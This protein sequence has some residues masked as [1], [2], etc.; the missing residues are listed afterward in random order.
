M[1]AAGSSIF[2]RIAGVSGFVAVVAGA[3][4]A[5]APQFMKQEGKIHQKVM[6]TGNL[7]H[8]IHTLG[9]LAVPFSN[10]PNLTGGL[11]CA[12]MVLFSGS[13]Y[14]AAITQNRRNG[15]LAPIGGVTLMAAWLT[16]LL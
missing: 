12:G 16:L 7:Y 10:R 9:L 1:A 14:L 13:C 15:L 2:Y 11:M 6:E 4:G 5:H 8:L 3:Y